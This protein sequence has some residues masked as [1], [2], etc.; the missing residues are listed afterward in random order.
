MNS[1]NWIHSKKDAGDHVV[2]YKKEFARHSQIRSASL[3][4]SARGV[5]EAFL[6]GKRVGDFIL[7][8]GF[9]TAFAITA[10]PS[11]ITTSLPITAL[12]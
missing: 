7:A 2:L 3:Y 1:A 9:T 5:Y 11:P 8:P 4:V 12:G 6:N 10:L